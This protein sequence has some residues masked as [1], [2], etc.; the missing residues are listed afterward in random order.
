MKTLITITLA[1]ILSAPG[2]SQYRDS[3]DFYLKKA[4]AYRYERRTQQ[5]LNFYEKAVQFDVTNVSALKAMGEYAL[6]IRNYRHA[7]NAFSRWHE[8]EPTND[9][10]IQQLATIYYQLGKYADALSFTKK[11]EQLHADKPMHFIAGMSY[12]YQ[13]D[14]VNAINRLLH[15]K[16]TDSTNAV[17]YYTIG[18]SYVELDRYEKAIPF[19]QM[20]ALIESSNAR[21]AYELALVYYA[22]PDDKNAIA[23]FEMAAKRGWVQNA[24]YFENLAHCY[25]NTGNFNK[26]T[27]LL[28]T[29]LEKRPYNI[30][31]TYTLGESFYRNAKYQDAINTWDQVLQMDTKNARSLYMIGITYQKMGEKEKGTAICEKAIQMDPSLGGLK[32]KKIDLGM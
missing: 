24:D 8:L 16:E 10:T 12:Y 13:E 25:M 28:Q 23:S 6:E 3:S 5:A 20:A 29:S 18:R 7:I 26:A 22:V 32:Q 14:F 11:W 2:F 31:V 27:E 19:Y 17:L 9:V 30:A 1:V 4:N 21:Y 15:A